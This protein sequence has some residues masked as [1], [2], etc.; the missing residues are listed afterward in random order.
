MEN[1]GKRIRLER[2]KRQLTLKQL[3]EQTNLSI[4]FLSEIERGLAQPSYSSLRKITQALGISM[5]KIFEDEPVKDSSNHLTFKIDPRHNRPGYI[6][7]A[8]AVRAGQRKKLIYP[9][10]PVAYELLTPDLSRLIQ[11]V[12]AKFEPGY[13]SGPEPVIDPPG[14]KFVLVLR[15]KVEFKVGDEIFHLNQGDSLSWP[16]D[17]PVSYR[18]VGDTSFEVILVVTPPGF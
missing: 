9:W 8:K 15:G 6:T 13:D 16:A 18:V 4:S 12:Y 10:A 5:L 1:A 14:E 2:R 3:S 7:E 11:A 17:A